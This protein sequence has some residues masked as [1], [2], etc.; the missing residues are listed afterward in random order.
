MD[1]EGS[2]SVAKLFLKK[3]E[4]T[5]SFLGMTV[6]VNSVG[7]F[8]ERP[9]DAAVIN[10]SLKLI[11]ALL[12]CGAEINALAEDEYTALHEAVEQGNVDIAEMLIVRGADLCAINQ[13]GN[14]PLDLASPE[15]I[16]RLKGH[17][18]SLDVWGGKPAII[19]E[20]FG[21]DVS[22]I[23]RYFEPDPRWMMSRKAGR[24]WMNP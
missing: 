12:E 4:D 17:P 22:A 19:A 6:Q 18:S 3:L 1:R 20:A 11:R 16:R 13:D 2:A 5:P 9:L 23:E 10:G 21:I 14:T 8:G 15:I 7:H 24:W